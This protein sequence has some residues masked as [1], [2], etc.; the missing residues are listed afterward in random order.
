M[1]E[2]SR[3]ER[4]NLRHEP[5]NDLEATVV[6]YPTD[7][8]TTEAGGHGTSTIS[9]A[10]SVH[11][12]FLTPGSRFGD[13]FTL[14]HQLGRGGMG[15]AW[16][17]YDETADRYVVLKFV[18][19]EIQHIQAAMDSVRGSFKKAHSLQHQHICPLYGLFTDPS[20]GLFVVMKFVDG[21]SLDEFRR[22]SIQRRGRLL[23][24]DA[25]NILWATAR[26][27]DYAHE[28]M[29]IHRDIK[30][31]NIM[32]SKTDGVQ[33]IDFGLA[34]EIRM[35]MVQYSEVA[36]DIAGTRPYMAPEQWRGRMQDARTDQY[37]LAATA[38]ELF[39]GTPPFQ[40]SDLG[41]LR[42]C[43]LND[44]PESIEAL[45]EHVNS[46]LL[47]GMAKKRDD[48]FPDCRSFVKAMA[49]HRPKVQ[50][51]GLPEEQEHL[52]AEGSA[53]TELPPETDT[54]GSHAPVWLPKSVLETDSY[55]SSQSSSSGGVAQPTAP[56]FPY[57]DAP[58]RQGQATV[59]AQSSPPVP[60]IVTTPPSSKK[61]EDRQVIR[62]SRE[63]RTVLYTLIVLLLVLLIVLVFYLIQVTAP[64]LP[65]PNPKPRPKARAG[66]MD[67]D[68]SPRFWPSTA[69]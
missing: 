1:P 25:I 13:N 46:A 67:F 50:G 36:M 64:P 12:S 42:E 22:R 39:C 41:I 45:P 11:N 32:I 49:E 47:R 10:G 17:A 27:L 3:D 30:P 48:R 19:K 63:E 18:P 26:A 68:T 37:A 28:R 34:E 31:Q 54:G 52:S 20:H 33:I 14:K 16:K 4:P 21:V 38:Y 60:V 43:V 65:P 62:A 57:P 15:E 35:S 6:R 58:H 59:P 40:G 5:E 7:P 55:A 8:R 44:Q 29:I 23:F 51:V 53:I 2:N 69:L 24:T 66:L 56:T 9:P 61:Q